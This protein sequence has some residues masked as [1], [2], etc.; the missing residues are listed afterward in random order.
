MQRAICLADCDSFFASCEQADNPALR[1]K[2]VCVMTGNGIG[3]IIVSR[4]K[5]AKAAGVKMGE[6]YFKVKDLYDNVTYLPVRHERYHQIS[7]QIMTIFKSF[8]P[9]VEAV[10]VDEAYIDLT[11]LDK[12]YKSSYTDIIRNIRQTVWQKVHI[13]VSIGLSTSK[14]LAKLASDLAKKQGGIFVIPPHKSLEL[15]GKTDICEVCGIGRQNYR[16]LQMA[17]IFTIAEFVAMS[18]TQTRK[19]FGV[20][21]VALKHELLGETV[22]PVNSKPKPPK[23]IQDT[24]VLSAFCQDKDLLRAALN[25]HIHQA[26]RRLRLW[27]GFCATAAV[28]LRTKD[29]RVESAKMK[30][31]I[32]T[33][34]EQDIAKAAAQLLEQLFRPREVYRSTGIELCDLSY[35]DSF[36]PSLFDET[37]QF[38]DDKLSQALDA[39]EE[40]F[41]KDIVKT[42][43]L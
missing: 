18:D 9:D 36:Q 30:L 3:G 39:L 1:N 14:T 10:S 19:A 28:M 17:G 42:G 22:S 12:L 41:G 8:S 27:N 7:Q 29:F 38:K 4:S 33:N 15:V 13:P 25:Y 11:S 43:W 40:K 21:G 37:P 23:S 31:P 16:H 6:P 20:N 5:E 2:A 34:S 24:S 32:A 26:C 35:Q